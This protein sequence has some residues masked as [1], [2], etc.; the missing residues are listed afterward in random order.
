MVALESE[1]VGTPCL[2]KKL[3]LDALEDHPYVRA[4][5]VEDPT[6]PFDIRDV[7]RLL[8]KIPKQDLAERM[9]DYLQKVNS[10]A[11]TR[12]LEFLAL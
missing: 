9:Q 8:L 2:R 3:F 10:L 1:S 6:N 4:V 12:Y 7:L 5:E 11:I